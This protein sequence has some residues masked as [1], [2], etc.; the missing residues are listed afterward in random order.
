[1][2]HCRIRGRM[3]IEHEGIQ[4]ILEALQS[5]Y[6]LVDVP[7]V[8][9]SAGRALRLE[10]FPAR[11]SPAFFGPCRLCVVNYIFQ[12]QLNISAAWCIYAHKLDSESLHA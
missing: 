12:S 2:W 1:M 8:R 3:L 4:A 7:K 6:W 9:R 10:G 5:P 11:K